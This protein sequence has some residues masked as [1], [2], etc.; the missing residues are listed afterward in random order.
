MAGESRSDCDSDESVDAIAHTAAAKGDVTLLKATI[1]QDPDVIDVMDK[2]G[3]FQYNP[4]IY[5]IFIK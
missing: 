4:T 5:K 3:K 2:D 1:L